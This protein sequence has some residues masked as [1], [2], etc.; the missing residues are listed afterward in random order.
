MLSLLLHLHSLISAIVPELT[1]LLLYFAFRRS[2]SA[3]ER[4]GT[5]RDIH[6]TLRAMHSAK[7]RLDNVRISV[8]VRSIVLLTC[9]VISSGRLRSIA[10]L[11][12]NVIS[13]GRLRS[14]TL[15]T[16]NVVISGKARRR[17]TKLLRTIHPAKADKNEREAHWGISSG[18]HLWVS[19]Q[20]TSNSNYHLH[21]GKP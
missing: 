9:N 11:T 7:E 16:C 20:T 5:R 14:I 3:K 10:L 1:D 4:L 8:K 13:S 12:C 6:G 19:P 2:S 17:R 15:L 18:S 21:A